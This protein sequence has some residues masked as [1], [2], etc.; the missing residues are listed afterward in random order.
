M[1]KVRQ[2]YAGVGDRLTSELLFILRSGG[3]IVIK[4]IEERKNCPM[5]NENGN[6]L[7]IGGFC[8]NGVSDEI[9]HGLHQ[10]YEMGL[11]AGSERCMIAVEKQKEKEPNVII[12]VYGRKFYFCPH[13]NRSLIK[14]IPGKPRH[15][16]D[17][18]QAIKWN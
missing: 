2:I 3:E 7:V 5:R 11:R 1:S 10:A 9:C 12:N 8:V 13:C 15:C 17:C 16:D 18:G 4:N 14:S 6:C